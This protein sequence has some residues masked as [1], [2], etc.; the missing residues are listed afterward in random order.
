MTTLVTGAAGLIA[1]R[2]VRK[3]LA[4]GE[5]TIA[6]DLSLN[7][8]RLN[9]VVDHALLSISRPTFQTSMHSTN[10]FREA[11]STG[12]STQPRYCLQLANLS[13]SIAMT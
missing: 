10:C 1:S 7:A 6:L 11:Q 4:Q 3:L 12:S 9:D 2:V 8:G 5:Q 13:Q